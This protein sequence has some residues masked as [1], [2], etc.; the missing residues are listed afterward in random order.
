MNKEDFDQTAWLG[1]VSRFEFHWVHLSEGT[2][3]HIAA[4]MMR[5]AGKGPLCN[6]RTR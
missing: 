4:H 6:L 3:S 5:N 1:C 2:F